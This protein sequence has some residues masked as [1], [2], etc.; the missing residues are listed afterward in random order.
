MTW[1]NFHLNLLGNGAIEI[2]GLVTMMYLC[3]LFNSIIHSFIHSGDLYSS[4]SREYTTQ[5]LYT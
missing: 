4:S 1:S 2:C 5:Q 3:K